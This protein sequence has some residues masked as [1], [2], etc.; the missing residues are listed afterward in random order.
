MQDPLKKNQHR[1]TWTIRMQS[2]Q[3]HLY[4]GLQLWKHQS[5]PQSQTLVTTKGC[6]VIQPCMIKSS[7]T[8]TNVHLQEILAKGLTMIFSIYTFLI[9]SWLLKWYTTL[10]IFLIC[11]I[12]KLIWFFLEE[13][14]WTL[15][16]VSKI[17]EKSY[18][19]VDF[20]LRN[21]FMVL[22]TILV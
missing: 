8:P 14:S 11:R 10:I 3:P 1:S 13:W 2:Y 18:N 9:S 6:G 15:T 7:N 5:R 19:T 20:L 16:R 4:R 22:V 12:F 21:L 17:E